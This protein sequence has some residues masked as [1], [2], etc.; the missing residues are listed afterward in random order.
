MTTFRVVIICLSLLFALSGCSR[1][2]KT[3]AA[4]ESA[5]TGLTGEN[6]WDPT[7]A[8]AFMSDKLSPGRYKNESGNHFACLSE[9]KNLDPG[10]PAN[11][12]AYYAKGEVGRARLVGLSLKVNRPESASDALKTFLEY[13]QQL[14]E[15]ATGVPLSGSAARSILAGNEGRGKVGSTNVEIVRQNSSDGKRYELNYIITPQL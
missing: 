15:K 5:S 9:E 1:F 10:S 4:G 3:P 6:G 8:C 14:S 13:S 2:S 11:N 12:I 7:A